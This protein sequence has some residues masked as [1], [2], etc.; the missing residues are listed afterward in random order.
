MKYRKNV[1]EVINGLIVNYCEKHCLYSP[2]IV[3]L[4]TEKKGVMYQIYDPEQDD[5]GN[6][7]FKALCDW[8]NGGEYVVYRIIYVYDAVDYVFPEYASM[9]GCLNVFK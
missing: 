5:H 2:V 9:R 6:I 7:H 3:I 1:D 8:Y 4:E